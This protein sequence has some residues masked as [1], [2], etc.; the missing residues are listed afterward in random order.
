M[1]HSRPTTQYN[2]ED[3]SNEQTNDERRLYNYLMRNYDNTIRPVYNAYHAI[4]I[5][6]G[7]TLTQIFDLVSTRGDMTL[8]FTPTLDRT[9]RTKC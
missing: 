9:R 1:F 2:P 4:N 8:L 3:Y 6:L 5:R 7:I